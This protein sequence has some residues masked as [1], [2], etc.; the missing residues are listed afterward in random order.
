M[1]TDATPPSVTDAGGGE[2]VQSFARGLAVIRAFDAEHPELT[3]TEVAQ[4][5]ATSRA[6]ARRFLGTLESLGYVRASERTFAL[7]PRVLELG[8]S[9]L[10][11]LSLPEIAQ[12]HLE[13]LSHELNE[14]S[15]LAVLDGAD[16]VYVARVPTR[17]I[18]RVNITIGAR[19]PAYATSLGRVLLAGLPRARQEELLRTSELRPYTD[20]TLV[21]VPALLDELAAV[22]E[23][24]WAL[25]EGEL[26]EGLRSIAAPVGDRTGAVV[27][28]VNV[29]MSD[30]GRSGRDDEAVVAALLR[31]VSA[32]E[33]DL[34]AR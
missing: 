25:V 9:Y 19:F 5:S 21:S 2:F 26:D 4:R 16:V 3:L 30:R 31:T 15:S 18:M 32:I 1:T 14:S 20:R 10:S 22:T 29:S 8:Y 27:A 11:A 28:A 23:R 17:R 33:A 6:A 12:P 13:R 7:T 34:T 24:G